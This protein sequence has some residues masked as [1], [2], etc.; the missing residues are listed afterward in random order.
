MKQLI[1]YAD[2]LDVI[3]NVYDMQSRRLLE[4]EVHIDILEHA[5][6]EKI[7]KLRLAKIA[8]PE[9]SVIDAQAFRRLYDFVMKSK[10]ETDQ[11]AMKKKKKRTASNETFKTLVLLLNASEQQAVYEEARPSFHAL[12]KSITAAVENKNKYLQS[13]A[14]SL[15]AG[16]FHPDDR[17][18]LLDKLNGMFVNVGIDSAKFIAH[19]QGFQ[20]VSKFYEW[21]SAMC[22]LLLIIKALKPMDQDQVKT[23][24]VQLIDKMIASNN[25]AAAE[26][27]FDAL[28]GC[29]KQ[30]FSDEYDRMCALNHTERL[31]D[32]EYR[33]LKQSVRKL[34]EIDR[35]SLTQLMEAVLGADVSRLAV[36]VHDTISLAA[37]AERVKGAQFHQLRP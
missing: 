2:V 31:L 1:T 10:N 24:A 7:K 29:A 26:F 33:F 4:K 19:I 12:F 20:R 13:S 23:V 6:E 22:H 16:V 14:L 3:R 27:L 35:M 18:A 25:V 21:M 9:N 15:F 34:I 28:N 37:L 17:P 11:V 30:L 36:P 8:H 5:I 32:G